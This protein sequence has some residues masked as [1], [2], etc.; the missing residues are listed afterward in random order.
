MQKS[1]KEKTFLLVAILSALFVCAPAIASSI[2]VSTEKTRA[3]LFLLGGQN[4]VGSEAFDTAKHVEN[5][6]SPWEVAS[7]S[8]VA[9]KGGFGAKGLYTAPT[10]MADDVVKA[11]YL[12]EVDSLAFRVK[13]GLHNILTPFHKR[14]SVSA[15][16]EFVEYGAFGRGPFTAKLLDDGRVL[17]GGNPTRTFLN[18]QFFHHELI[19]VSQMVKNPTTLWTQ[20]P[21]RMLH[22]PIQIWTAHGTWG[23]PATALVGWWILESTDG[24]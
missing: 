14:T 11:A 13:L 2:D 1:A 5:Y 22:E 12:K 3:E 15:V 6:D 18:R 4:S 8:S 19:H 24:D 20:F 23:I 16:R 7:E 10:G 9:P 21:L 17:F